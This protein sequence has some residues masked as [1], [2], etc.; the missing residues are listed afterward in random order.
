MWRA[1]QACRGSAGCSGVG[2]ALKCDVG[3]PLVGDPCL[4]GQAPTK[5]ATTQELQACQAGTYRDTLCTPPQHC[6]ALGNGQFG[7]K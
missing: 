5:C 6:K 4:V 1:L 3:Q 2:S 7:C